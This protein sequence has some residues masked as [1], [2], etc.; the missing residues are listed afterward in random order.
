MRAQH[1]APFQWWHL[2]L[3]H[4]SA[5]FVKRTWGRDLKKDGPGKIPHIFLRLLAA[6]CFIY[7]SIEDF[8]EKYLFTSMGG[9]TDTPYILDI[10]NDT[11]YGF[12][13]PSPPPPKEILD[14]PLF[15]AEKLVFDT[16][17]GI[18]ISALN[19]ASKIVVC[20]RGSPLGR[21]SKTLFF[22]RN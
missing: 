8:D 9:I 18:P 6:I 13:P 19:E 20:C 3:Q 15:W 17:L 4:A 16:K 14:G 10:Y 22:K 2:K 5:I 1:T 7:I 12:T 11:R 21:S